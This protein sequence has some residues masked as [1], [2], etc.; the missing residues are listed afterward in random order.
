MDANDLIDVRYKG[1]KISAPGK[2][3]ITL[4]IDDLENP[5]ASIKL[6]ETRFSF[7]DLISWFDVLAVGWYIRR[8]NEKR[9]KAMGGQT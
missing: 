1:S 3:E 5:Q 6:V 2:I 4:E 7:G 8:E 9:K